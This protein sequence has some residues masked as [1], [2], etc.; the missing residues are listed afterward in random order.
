MSTETLK[1]ALLCALET[2]VRHF[3]EGGTDAKLGMGATH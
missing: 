2:L 3:Q 1:A